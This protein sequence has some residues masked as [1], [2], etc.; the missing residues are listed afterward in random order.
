MRVFILFI[1]T[2]LMGINTAFAYEIVLPKEKKTIVNTK[3]AFFIGKAKNSEIIEINDQKVYIAQNGAFAHSIKLKDGENRIVIRSN[4]NTQVYKIY[5]NPAIQNTKPELL[6]FTPQ[7]YTVIKDN[8]PLRSSPVDGGMNRLSHLFEETS[9]LIDGEKGD[10]YRVFLS[11]NNYAWISKKHVKKSNK[12]IEPN[13][14]TTN[15]ETYKNASVYSIEFTEKIPYTIE[16]NDKELIFKTYNPFVSEESV[17]TLNIK[18]P[19]KYYYKINLNK[20]QYALKI[21]EFPTPEQNLEGITITIDPG[22]GGT[23]KGAIGCLGDE[24]KK[25]NLQIAEQLKT[26]LENLGA[27][28]VMTRECDAYI[29]LD[30]RVKIAQ[31]NYS[32]LF[33]SI[34]LNSIPDIEMNVHKNK[35]TSVFYYNPNSKML[36]KTLE[37]SITQALNT[38]KAGTHS[39]SFAVLR[40][41]DYIGVLVE[42]AYMTNPLD[43]VLYTKE[44]FPSET[45]K[46]ITDGILNFL[47]NEN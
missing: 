34:H 19:E 17:Y 14:I 44:D 39:A 24:E 31:D 7:I 16:E 47:N 20:G 21:N 32:D 33:I 29:S 26:L 1:I 10:F 4:F 42:V 22:H 25:I 8:S 27:N 15:T 23:E 11:K 13:F 41:T 43:S 38:K 46:A 3:Y 35:G 6:E 9:L 40:P 28:V 45:A 37:N 18:K 5:R 36:A 12:K 2:I 30:D